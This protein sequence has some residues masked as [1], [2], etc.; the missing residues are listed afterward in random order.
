M[1]NH[2]SANLLV[3][4][5]QIIGGFGSG[6]LVGFHGDQLGN[7]QKVIGNTGNI[8]ELSVLW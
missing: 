4:V 8:M 6:F 2:F 1:V 3:E 7:Q 5:F